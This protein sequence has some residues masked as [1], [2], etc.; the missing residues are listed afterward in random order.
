MKFL[1]LIRWKNLII[2]IIIQYFTRYFLIAPFY[3]LQNIP[4]Q[5][6][7]FDFLLLVISAV[8][9]AAAGYI[10]N[11]IFD[12][13]IDIIN[14]PDKMVINNGISAKKAN[15]I[16]WILNTVAII[17]GIYLSFK[18]KIISLSLL[19]IISA[20]V[21][22]FYSLRYKRLFLWGNIVVAL[23]GVI[24]IV[25]VWLFEFF[26]THKNPAIFTNG[27][28]VYKTISYFVIAYAIIS[29]IITLIREFIKDI[30]DMDGDLRWGCNTLPVVVGVKTTKKITIILSLLIIILIAYFQFKLFQ[31]NMDYFA[32]ILIIVVQAPFAYMIYK[33]WKAK[34][35]DDFHFISNMAKIIMFL[36][37]LTMFCVYYNFL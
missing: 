23:M 26:A 36:G 1:N 2:I 28:Q 3:H 10:I 24:L 8:S 12:I 20:T 13:Q 9:L 11:D 21:F 22:Y 37:I 7:S 31:M 32:E 29:F 19:F 33:I 14:K 30:E 15:F 17:I 6:S 27:I 5:M 18:V 4:L 35:K 25:V 34:E 16:Y